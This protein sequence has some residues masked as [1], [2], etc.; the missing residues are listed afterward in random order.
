[1]KILFNKKFLNHN[2]ESYA[3]GNYRLKDFVDQC[4]ETEINGE[5][6]IPLV[7]TERYIRS[8]KEACNN[9][10]VLAEV[11]LSPDSY[12]A[13]CIAVGLTVLASEQNDF[14]VVRPPGHHA[15]REK[16]D[17]F[18][19]FNNLAIATQKLIIEGK[20]VFILDI[21]GHHGDGTQSIFYDTDKVLYCSIHQQYT[22]PW[23]GTTDETGVKEGV[24]YTMN[25]P[26]SAGDGDKEFLNAVDTAIEKAKEFKPDVVGVSVGL[27]AY[28][29]DRLLSL[30]Y[31]LN[32]YYECGYRLGKLFKNVFAVL[33]G[34]YHF[35]IKKCV[36]NFIDGINKS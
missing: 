18:C 17:G 4:D 36:D 6:Y 11:N 27:D 10:S 33:E 13:A 32:A 24:G 3:E 29:N 1:M 7:H 23:T 25:F 15:K 22:Y 21:D 20:K 12:E 35:D 26:L 9:H 2:H 16:A 31:S 19:L 5:K 30:N 8:V 34:G 28:E 14:A